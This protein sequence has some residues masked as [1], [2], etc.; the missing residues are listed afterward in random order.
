LTDEQNGGLNKEQRR[1]FARL[2][3]GEAT[4]LRQSQEALGIEPLDE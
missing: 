4:L 2:A 3:A 1:E